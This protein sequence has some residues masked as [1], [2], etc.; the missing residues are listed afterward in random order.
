[1]T[2]FYTPQPKWY[3]KK[4]RLKAKQLRS[5]QW[6]KQKLEGGLCYYCQK[7]FTSDKLTMDHK[8]PLAKGGVS[9]KSNIVIACRD[10]NRAK[11]TKTSVDIAL[12][13]ID[14]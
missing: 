5:S 11:G 7:R 4:Q 6:W 8:L 1:M 14:L 10:C 2:I 12:E 9:S 13:K 3:L